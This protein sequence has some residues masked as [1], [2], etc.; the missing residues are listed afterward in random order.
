MW[1]ALKRAGLLVAVCWWLWQ[2]PVGWW[3]DEDA[4]VQMDSVTGH[5]QSAHHWQPHRQSSAWWSLPQPCRSAPVAARARWSE[6]PPSARRWSLASAVACGTSPASHPRR[7]SRAGSGLASSAATR[8]C[9]WSGSSPSA[10]P[11]SRVL[12]VPGRRPA[13]RWS[14]RVAVDD[15]RRSVQAAGDP[16]SSR[17]SLSPCRRW[18]AACPCLPNTHQPTPS[19]AARTSRVDRA[20]GQVGRQPSSPPTTRGCSAGRPAGW[21]RRLSHQWRRPSWCREVSVVVAARWR[22]KVASDAL[23]RW[24][25]APAHDETTS[26]AGPS[27]L[28]VWLTSGWCSARRQLGGCWGES[29]SGPPVS[30]AAHARRR[31]SPPYEQSSVVHCQLADPPLIQSRQCA[32]IFSSQCPVST[33]FPDMLWRWLSHQ[34]PAHATSASSSCRPLKSFPCWTRCQKEHLRKK[35]SAKCVATDV[36]SDVSIDASSRS[37]VMLVI[38]NF[39]EHCMLIRINM[40]TKTV[41][42]GLSW[43]KLC[44][45]VNSRNIS[46]KLGDKVYIWSL[47]NRVKFRTKIPMHC[48][49]I[50]KSHRGG[51]F[52]G[53]PGRKS[54][55]G[56]PTRHQLWVTPN[57]PQKG[58][59]HPH[60]WFF[61]EI[62]TKTH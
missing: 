22:A 35:S 60:L 45:F 12:C 49:N 52:F 15:S 11:A 61:A 2:E 40:E 43:L 44:S 26:D 16:G 25:S 46:I 10:S 3:S 58:F 59:R 37:L 24:W 1:V 47:N 5:V 48:C 31:F 56:F 41:K 14:R 55:M 42:W 57:F 13:G 38:S 34:G 23:R 53:S 51:F 18:S 7:G 28:C 54:N 9:W 4:D 17:R 33:V 29:R 19:R 21:G 8:S 32:D 62:S 39:S 27:W 30:R 6:A 36:N 20:D 50:N